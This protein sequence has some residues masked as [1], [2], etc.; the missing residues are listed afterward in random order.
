MILSP[1]QTRLYATSSTYSENDLYT[2]DVTD[3]TNLALS[4]LY[5]DTLYVPFETR[6]YLPL[7]R[8][9]TKTTPS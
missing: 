8:F 5:G 6:G 4:A 3:P 2:F 1:D 7:F 9:R